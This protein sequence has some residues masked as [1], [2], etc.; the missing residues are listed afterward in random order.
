MERSVEAL[1]CA[2]DAA[3]EGFSV[4]AEEDPW[5][6]SPYRWL[7]ELQS[8]TRGKAGEQIVTTWLQ[9]EGFTVGP[10]GSSN[11]DRRIELAEVEIKLSTRWENGEYRFQQIR[12]QKYKYVILLGVSPD[13][14][15]VWILPKKVALRYST[16]QHTGKGGAETRWLCFTAE[17]PPSWLTRYGG[18]PESGLIAAKRYLRP[19]HQ[20]E[21][22]APEVSTQVVIVNEETIDSTAIEAQDLV[23]YVGGEDVEAP[24]TVV[25]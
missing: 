5:S 8:R 2:F 21:S 24:R 3:R 22:T 13:Q 1:E 19:Q 20:P 11:S 15:N 4:A 16:P 17:N 10:A 25:L 18:S 7:R 12:D 9:G 23:S 14:L 6:A